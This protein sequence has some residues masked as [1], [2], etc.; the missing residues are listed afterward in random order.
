MPRTQD[1]LFGILCLALLGMLVLHI[2]VIVAALVGAFACGSVYLFAGMM[3]SATESFGQRLFTSGF[4]SIV[5]SS[6][7]LI[8]PGTLGSSVILH[9]IQ[10]AVMGAAALPPLAAICFEVVRTPRVIRGIQRWLGYD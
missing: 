9:D 6:L 7:I 8:L 1:I 3:P 4:L 5:V 10:K 2:G